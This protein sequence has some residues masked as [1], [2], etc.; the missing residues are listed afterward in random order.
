MPGMTYT[1][2]KP[3]FA[4]ILAATAVLAVSGC[5]THGAASGDAGRIGEVLSQW[6]TAYMA[7]D[8]EALM[9]L[10]PDDYAHKGKDKAGI[11]KEMAG[12]MEENAAYDVQVNVV[13]ATVS[14][15][16]GKATV[17]PVALS[18]TAGSDT[19]RLELTKR[20]GRWRIT[21]TDL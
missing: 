9:R 14:I 20:E 19:A 4:C 8:M 21:G 5:A 11:E 16:G 6:R 10:Y 17:M 7:R 15:Q 13:D 2:P 3:I 1:P 12:L 18:G